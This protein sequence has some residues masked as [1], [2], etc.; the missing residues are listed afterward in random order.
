VAA[1]RPRERAGAVGRPGCCAARPL[2]EILGAVDTRL[3]RGRRT[4]A[5]SPPGRQGGRRG[6]HADR[7]HRGELALTHGIRGGRPSWCAA[8]RVRG[9]P[10]GCTWSSIRW[11][12]GTDPFCLRR[13][14]WAAASARAAFWA[15]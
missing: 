1:G 13:A 2:A 11:T 8:R 9:Q 12:S 5:S 4:R 7:R 14:A 3:P 6:R 10:R 15:C